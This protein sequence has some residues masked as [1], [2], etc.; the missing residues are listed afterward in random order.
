[1]H[2]CNHTHKVQQYEHYPDMP[3]DYAHDDSHQHLHAELKIRKIQPRYLAY[4][5]AHRVTVNH[6]QQNSDLLQV[7]S[8]HSQ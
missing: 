8:L 2:D 1:M 5:H 7:T 6:S 3:H 4:I